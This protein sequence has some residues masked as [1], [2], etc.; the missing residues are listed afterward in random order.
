MNRTGAGMESLFL[1]GVGALI[2]LAACSEH[3]TESATTTAGS[4]KA[5]TASPAQATGEL[6]FTAPSEWISETPSS[7]MR[8]AQ[9]R[10]PRVSGDSE[11]AEMVIFFFREQGGSVQANLD[12]WIGQFRKADGS[13]ASEAAKISHKESHGIPLTLVDVSGT[14]RGSAGPMMA[15][16]EPK[17][18]FRMLAAIAETPSG[19]WFFKL[20][21]PEETVTQWEESFHVFLDTL[22]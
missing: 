15:P 5:I 14:Y 1:I 19:P 12:R 16:A 20:T 22:H 21:G 8:R 10:L 9:Y 17:P 13:P 3:E 4:S 6:S 18:N 7:R 11:D 2:I